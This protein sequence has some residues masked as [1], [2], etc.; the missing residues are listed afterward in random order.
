MSSRRRRYIHLKL[1]FYDFTFGRVRLS[2][3]AQTQSAT[4]YEFLIHLHARNSS[5]NFY[6]AASRSCGKRR[7]A[8]FEIHLGVEERIHGE[9]INSVIFFRKTD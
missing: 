1:N 9:M 7:R 8:P 3:R 4:S 5:C 6:F 2:L